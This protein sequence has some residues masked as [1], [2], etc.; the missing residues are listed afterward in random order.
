[1]T[2]SAWTHGAASGAEGAVFL[3]ASY[4]LVWTAVIAVLIVALV[5]TVVT[6]L[7]SS[8]SD[9]AKAL[10][11]VLALVVPVVTAIA[12]LVLGAD[13]RRPPSRRPDRRQSTGDGRPARRA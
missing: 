11:V 4:D 8:L 13:A 3:P 6:V 12:W 5:W 7:R 2:T 9:R 1:M 10:W